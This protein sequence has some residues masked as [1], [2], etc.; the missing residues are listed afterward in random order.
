MNLLDQN[1]DKI[2]VLCQKHNVKQLYAFGS[3][4]TN[5]FTQTSD[6]DLLIQFG[7]IGLLEYFDNYMALK[8]QRKPSSNH[9]LFN[10]S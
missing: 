10:L 7:Q 5:K 8:E 9:V 6:I 3:V 1:K 4:T 2:S